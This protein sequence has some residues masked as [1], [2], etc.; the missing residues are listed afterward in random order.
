MG[1][2]IYKGLTTRL[3][4]TRNSTL[5]CNKCALIYDPV[6][7]STKLA[8]LQV[9]GL[10]VIASPS[11][12]ETPFFPDAPENATETATIGVTLGWTIAYDQNE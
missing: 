5:Q 9:P 4:K 1:F 3:P 11:S 7:P 6:F 12:A 2:N 10:P 8:I